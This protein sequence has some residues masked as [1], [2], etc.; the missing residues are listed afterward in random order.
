MLQAEK[1]LGGVAG[2]YQIAECPKDLG[3][4]STHRVSLSKNS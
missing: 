3:C 4:Q 2:A 1:V